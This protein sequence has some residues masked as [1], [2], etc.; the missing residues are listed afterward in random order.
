MGR[1]LPLEV[2]EV[3][4]RW[5]DADADDAALRSSFADALRRSLLLRVALFLSLRLSSHP[6]RAG[7]PL[8]A[9][10]LPAVLDDER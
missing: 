4:E 7:S 2:M 1:R 5:A 3:E 10:A 8:E 6:L 9:L